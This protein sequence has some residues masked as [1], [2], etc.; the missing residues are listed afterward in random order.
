MFLS[1]FGFNYIFPKKQ[2]QFRLNQ[3]P[4]IVSLSE[5]RQTCNF[6]LS[7]CNTVNALNSDQPTTCTIICLGS[8]GRVIRINK[9]SLLLQWTLQ[10]PQHP[11]RKQKGHQR[12]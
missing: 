11:K 2:I 7:E 6:G 10:S 4:F 5:M 12:E 1:L 3:A 9:I 8:F